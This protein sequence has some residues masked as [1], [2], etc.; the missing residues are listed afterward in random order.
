MLPVSVCLRVCVHVLESTECASLCARMRISS[1]VRVCVP[2]SLSSWKEG[3]NVHMW[4]PTFV[5]NGVPRD[6]A[7]RLVQA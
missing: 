3:C 1:H 7:G 4:Y 2:P 5:A 6:I